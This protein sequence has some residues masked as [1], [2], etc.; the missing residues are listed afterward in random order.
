MIWCEKCA[1][2]ILHW[3]IWRKLFTA[4]VQ[5]W[6]D[7][8]STWI[9]GGKNN[10]RQKKQCIVE[11]QWFISLVW[12]K[13]LLFL[14][15]DIAPSKF[16]SNFHAAIPRGLCDTSGPLTED[17]LYVKLSNKFCQMSQ[18]S[19]KTSQPL[20]CTSADAKTAKDSVKIMDWDGWKE[21]WGGRKKWNLGAIYKDKFAWVGFSGIRQTDI[22]QGERYVTTKD[23]W[24]PTRKTFHCFS[25]YLLVFPYM[26][27]LKVV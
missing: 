20:F 1:P 22:I 18:I 16:L 25:K 3:I 4:F 21:V 7:H 27:R 15:I 6:I 10:F 23:N 11:N 2:N 13:N 14:R 19:H 5:Y 12:D 24:E 26:I 17:H 8:L 9:I